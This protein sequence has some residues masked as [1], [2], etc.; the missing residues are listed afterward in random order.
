MEPA[1]REI[2]KP[3][4]TT[5]ISELYTKLSA[6]MLL[7]HSWSG[8]FY[9]Y[10]HRLSPDFSEL[11]PT[12]YTPSWVLDFTSPAKI[13]EAER[14]PPTK[15]ENVADVS[16]SPY[17]LDR[18]F[19]MSGLLL[20]EIGHPRYELL[21]N[22]PPG[23]SSSGNSFDA[24]LQKIGGISGYP[25]IAWATRYLEDLP[26]DISIVHVIFETA[27]F[28]KLSVAIEEI[29]NMTTICLKQQFDKHVN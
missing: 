1:F 8:L 21:E 15:E 23:E 27:N 17:I 25:S 5:S 7:F 22:E 9:Y 6:Y 20:D 4:Y 24:F 13:K 26:Y 29:L 18:V 12:S 2:F 11:Q 10:P 19:F 16:D 14:R 3:D 28:D